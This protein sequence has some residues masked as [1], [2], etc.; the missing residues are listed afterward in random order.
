M[1]FYESIA[2]WYDHIF[3]VS[4]LQ[5][6]FV[7]LKL[8][9]LQGKEII[10]VGCGTGNLSLQLA[11]EGAVVTGVDLDDQML[12][13]ARDKAKSLTN[14]RFLQS[15]MLQLSNH[16]APASLDGIVCFGNT[17][18]HLLKP[19]EVRRFFRQCHEILKPSGVFLLQMINY[20][21]V[22]DNDLRGLPPIENNQIRFDREYQLREQDELINFK[23]LLTVKESG[24]TIKN[25]V[26]LQPLRRE[27]LTQILEDTRFG[28]VDLYGSFEMSVFMPSSLPFVAEIRPT[29]STL[30]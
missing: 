28:I 15:D 14:V 20:D 17:L 18:P 27:L 10:D 11:Q 16:F 2:P 13:V 24:K 30:L 8:E 29:S 1:S 9:G 4:P 3:P 19:G 22:L 25:S 5:M 26:V 6:K 21:N 7:N 12:D 23:T